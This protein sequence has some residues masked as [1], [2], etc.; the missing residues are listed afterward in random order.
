[1]LA[2]NV[3]GPDRAARLAIGIVLVPVGLVLLGGLAGQILGITVAA[4][5]FVGLA[6]GLSGFCPLYVPFGFS[7]APPQT[8]PRS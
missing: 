6:T 5:G 2:R 7:T 1:M 8:A 3:A 4:V